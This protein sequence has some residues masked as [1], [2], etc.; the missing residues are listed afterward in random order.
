[1]ISWK[2]LAVTALSLL[3][4]GCSGRGDYEAGFEAGLKAAATSTTMPIT[5][6]VPTTTTTTTTMPT[7]TTTMPTTTTTRPRLTTTTRR[8]PA[9]TTTTTRV[10]TRLRANYNP[11]FL[12]DEW[13][14]D[15]LE[16]GRTK[17]GLIQMVKDN[18]GFDWGGRDF[19]GN[20]YP[21]EAE[22]GVGYLT[23]ITR[24]RLTTTT[25]RLPALTTTTTRVVT[26]LRA[27]Y[28]PSFLRDE[29]C[30]DWLE[31]GRTKAGLI[32]MVKDNPGFDWGGRD[33]DGNG[34]PCE[35][36][37]GVGY[38][39]ATTTRPR[40]TTTTDAFDDCWNALTDDFGSA[41]GLVNDRVF[42]RSL[43][44]CSHADWVDSI[45]IVAAIG[46]LGCDAIYSLFYAAPSGSRVED[47]LLDAYMQC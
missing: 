17:A 8:L 25:R 18:P 34:Y 42:A 40:F 43:V 44:A 21:C 1:M 26:R 3:V 22:L 9:L 38:L 33:F 5:T 2:V 20:G 19:D 24:P 4:V 35:A 14:W 31:D 47:R 41:G 13:C 27:N 37:L 28:N 15:W 7:T 23:T 30:W 16:D 36:E 29:W 45:V 10:V 6:T 11:S 32:Q 46:G 39:T 12:R